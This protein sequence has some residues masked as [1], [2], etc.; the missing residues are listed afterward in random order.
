MRDADVS[1]PS[2]PATRR[3]RL[4]AAQ[5]RTEI[6]AA[7][8]TVFGERGYHGASIDLIAREAGVSKA[9]I[10]EH[11]AAKRELHASLLQ[12]HVGELF[13][14]LQANA[15]LGATGEERLRGGVAAFFSFVAEH[16]EAFRLLTRDAADPEVADAL[17]GVQ[18][19]V[20]GLLVALMRADPD[21]APDRVPGADDAERSRAVELLA[22]QLSGAMQALAAWWAHHPDVP[23]QELVDRAADFAWTGLQRLREPPAGAT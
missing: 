4:P 18:E 1:R 15:A 3:P 14:R 19:Q 20:T 16:R 21:A 22:T 7:A 11:F 8:M 6:L 5:R 12:Q 13:A 17:E 23:Q 10:Y 9:L 2:T